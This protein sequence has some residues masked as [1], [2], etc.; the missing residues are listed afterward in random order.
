MLEEEKWR[1]GL[2]RRNS[3]TIDWA[4]TGLPEEMTVVGGTKERGRAERERDRVRERGRKLDS[5]SEK[6]R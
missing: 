1:E 4:P 5:H 6:Q 2:R 3:N